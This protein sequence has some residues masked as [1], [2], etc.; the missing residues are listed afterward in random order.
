MAL[1]DGLGDPDQASVIQFGDL[2]WTLHRLPV[3]GPR[4][5]AVAALERETERLTRDAPLPSEPPGPAEREWLARLEA[6]PPQAGREG[7]RV[8]AVEGSLPIL[9]GSKWEARSVPRIAPPRPRVVT[10]ALAMPR[11]DR[12]WTVC[13]FR[14]MAEQGGATSRAAP[15]PLPPEATRTL[16]V[17]L[18]NGTCAVGFRGPYRPETWQA[19]YGDWFRSH[20]W[21]TVVAW[22]AGRAS[23]S[24]RFV[25]LEP[26]ARQTADLHFS[27]ADRRHLTGLLLWSRSAHATESDR[28]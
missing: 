4:D 19:Y 11:T 25:R 24:A 20:G 9:V 28:P 6:R 1:A 27:G 2:P 14:P 13:V 5:A 8:D 21:Q 18:E 17:Y 26:G 23:W 10:W 7:W 12:Q 3:Q 15:V 22:R 16:A